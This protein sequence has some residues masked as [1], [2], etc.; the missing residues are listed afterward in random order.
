MISFRK[1]KCKFF[2]KTNETKENKINRIFIG[3]DRRKKQ[4]HKTTKQSQING[5]LKGV[6]VSS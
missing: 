1:F 2:R 4:R 5:R 6:V 3:T